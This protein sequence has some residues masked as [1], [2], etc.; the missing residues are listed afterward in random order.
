MDVLARRLDTLMD[1]DVVTVADTATY[2]EVSLLMNTRKTNGVY[3]VDGR[4]R[5]I[6]IVSS[7]VLLRH[8]Q[9]AHLRDPRNAFLAAFESP[10]VFVRR[11]K[12][13]AQDRV[14]TFMRQPIHVLKA[15]DSLLAAATWLAEYRQLPVVD[16][17]GTPIGTIT[18]THLKRAI[19]EILE[20]AR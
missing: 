16:A 10:D 20:G 9:P 14:T 6:G 18:R 1:R 12:E 3:V 8:V 13:V 19:V 2:A 5:P 15:S 4:G 11:V 17:A 7:Q